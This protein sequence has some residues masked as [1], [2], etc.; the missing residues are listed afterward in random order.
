[1]TNKLTAATDEITS[2][3]VSLEREQLS[4][5][6]LRTEL[7]HLQEIVESERVTTAEL[8]VF[9]E[10]EKGEKDAALLR[11]AQVS[12]D[13]EIV[14]QENRQQGIEN[15]ELQNR[16]ENLEDDL[17]NK[18]K[19]VEQAAITLKE[20]EQKVAK[21]E[22]AECNREKLQGNERILKSSLLDL[23]EQLIEKNKVI[24]KVTKS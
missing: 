2:L 16:L 18:T 3:R 19:E 6:S 21:L 1:M 14:K 8:R 24:I 11:N 5:S 20:F 13:I 23:E 10:K 17:V 9:L 15:I 7:T 12:Q 22:E 4:N